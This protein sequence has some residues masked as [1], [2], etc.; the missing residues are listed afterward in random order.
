MTAE[1]NT[2]IA[3]TVYTIGNPIAT[4]NFLD[5]MFVSLVRHNNR[6]PFRNSRRVGSAFEVDLSN[7]FA[8]TV[9]DEN[10]ISV[11]LSQAAWGVDVCT[12]FAY[13]QMRLFRSVTGTSSTTL[14]VSLCQD[15][16]VQADFA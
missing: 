5:D 3:E 14:C 8:P 7:G 11:T 13:L 2:G 9:S 4:L 15:H 12:R 1:S 10:A 16:N 6:M